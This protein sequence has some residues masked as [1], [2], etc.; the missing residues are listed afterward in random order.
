MCTARPRLTTLQRPLSKA[1]EVASS[2]VPYLLR[3]YDSRAPITQK[4]P[5]R[6]RHPTEN[7]PTIAKRRSGAEI[8]VMSLACSSVRE[9]RDGCTA[10]D[11]P[12]VLQLR[13]YNS[14]NIYLMTSFVSGPS[15]FPSDATKQLLHRHQATTTVPAW[16]T[17]KKQ[18]VSARLER[19]N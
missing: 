17:H 15:L 19:M 7:P 6:E 1:P 10:I 3:P 5:L 12:T 2:G 14:L 18:Q 16:W 9:S 8:A 4:H 11:K 13:R